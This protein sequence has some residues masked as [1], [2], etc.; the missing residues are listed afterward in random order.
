MP[1]KVAAMNARGALTRDFPPDVARLIPRLGS[2]YDHEV[3]A[4]ARAIE[5]TLKS[6]KLDWH[7]VAEAVSAPPPI[8]WQP[9]R[10]ESHESAE[11][12][13]WLETISDENWLNDWTRSFIANI[14]TRQS[15]H[16]LSAKQR[17]CAQNIIAEAY[18]RGV[19]VDR[20]A[21]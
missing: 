1:G 14:L 12:R 3:V 6:Q 4:T 13:T 21:A 16:S 18:G 5:R 10:T 8:P 20:R 15:L 9:N 7:D 17:T 2:P 19:R 11:M